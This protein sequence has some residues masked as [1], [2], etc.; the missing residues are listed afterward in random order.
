MVFFLVCVYYCIYIYVGAF[1]RFT[2]SHHSQTL[3]FQGF[4]AETDTKKQPFRNCFTTV[5]PPKKQLKNTKKRIF[6]DFFKKR[7]KHDFFHFYENGLFAFFCC[8][9][10]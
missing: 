6:F 5:S 9:L 1:H 7:K 2:V 8:V 10:V 4:R 3:I